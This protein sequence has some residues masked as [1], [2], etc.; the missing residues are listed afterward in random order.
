MAWLCSGSWKDRGHC[1]GMGAQH[2][3]LCWPWWQR[4]SHSGRDPQHH[5]SPPYWGE[6]WYLDGGDCLAQPTHPCLPACCFSTLILLHWP[7]Q[8]TIAC[9]PPGQGL[10]A[11]LR[12]ILGCLTK[13]LLAVHVMGVKLLLCIQLPALHVTTHPS[14]SCSI[15]DL[16]V[17]ALRS[18]RTS[19]L[20]TD[21]TRAGAEASKL[22]CTCTIQDTTTQCTTCFLVLAQDWHQKLHNNTTPD[23]IVICEAF[24]IFL[25][26]NADNGAYWRHLTDNGITRERLEGFDRA[27]K[28]VP[29][30]LL[31]SLSPFAC[32]VTWL[33]SSRDCQR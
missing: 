26:N 25:E 22:Q 20:I 21:K 18:S 33:K 2:A 27:I 1:S 19:Y 9:L 3:R 8:I 11:D 4:S 16:F 23:D 15:L 6:T 31:P 29:T 10:S 5:A 32:L 28:V 12:I 30:P 7:L 13:P 17:H 14:P 24:I